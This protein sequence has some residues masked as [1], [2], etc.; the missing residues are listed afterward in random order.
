[1]E[2]QRRILKRTNRLG[3]KERDNP[4][5]GRCVPQSWGVFVR[6]FGYRRLAYVSH[7]MRVRSICCFRFGL[8]KEVPIGSPWYCWNSC[9]KVVNKMWENTSKSTQNRSYKPPFCKLHLQFSIVFKG[10]FE[11]LFRLL[12]IFSAFFLFTYSLFEKKPP[13]SP[14]KACLQRKVATISAIDSAQIYLFCATQPGQLSILYR[15]ASHTSHYSFLDLDISQSYMCS[16]KFFLEILLLVFSLCFFISVHFQ[17]YIV[18]FLHFIGNITYPIK[19]FLS[20]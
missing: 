3:H 4:V 12:Q 20:T 5:V 2:N 6:Y 14:P 16:S 8:R 7:E 9:R 11:I 15:E 13:Q 1:M 18:V 10:E 19:T 17:A